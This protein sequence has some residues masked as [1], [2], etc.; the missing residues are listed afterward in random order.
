MSVVRLVIAWFLMAALPLQGFAAATMAFCDHGPFSTHA[1]HEEHTA[2]GHRD[3]HGHDENGFPHT[4]L[5]DS[6]GQE[7]GGKVFGAEKQDKAHACG[8]C[9]ACCHVVALSYYPSP[10]PTAD[11]ASGELHE[12]LVRIFT[13]ASPRPDK[14]PRA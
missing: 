9:G 5:S 4:S 3:A 7:H 11:L 1:A 2:H 10:M 13:R 8:I 14:P 12:P 6:A